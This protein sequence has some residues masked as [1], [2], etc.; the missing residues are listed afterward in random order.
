MDGIVLPM[1]QAV[2][3]PGQILFDPPATPEEMAAVW[4]SFSYT[5]RN[6]STVK[7]SSVS[8]DGTFVFENPDP[9]QWD[10]EVSATGL[11][12]GYYLES[13]SFRGVDLLRD[14]FN[15]ADAPGSAVI[16]RAEDSPGEVTGRVVDAR[17]NLF[18]GARITLVPEGTRR[19]RRDVY[20]S[21]ESDEEGT[22]ALGAIPP[23]SY[24]VFAWESIP[25]GAERNT[26]FLA[27]YLG[28]DRLI[29]VD[30]NVAVD[31]EVSLIRP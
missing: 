24:R 29:T 17:G 20:R 28:R 26:D 19:G 1:V 2:D 23:G 11:P 15:P 8:P 4:L 6:G 30:E 25:E 10:W 5:G 18:E 14:A 27:P 22:F 9:V 7:G 12:E 16:L 21:I 13:A 3:V 31:V